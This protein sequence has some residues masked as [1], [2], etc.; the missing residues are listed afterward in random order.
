MVAKKVYLPVLLFIFVLTASCTIDNLPLEPKTPGEESSAIAGRAFYAELA[1]AG[2]AE[3]TSFTINTDEL[4]KG[5]QP[6]ISVSEEYIYKYY[7]VT[8]NG[9]W[10]KQT[11]PQATFGD[12]N[13]IKSSASASIDTTQL[14]VGSNH[15][16]AYACSKVENS[17]NCHDNKWQIHEFKVLPKAAELNATTKDIWENFPI[18]MINLQPEDLPQVKDFI[19]IAMYYTVFTPFEEAVHPLRVK[20]AVGMVDAA[21]AHDLKTIIHLGDI[22][23]PYTVDPTKSNQWLQDN[24]PEI[25]GDGIRKAVVENEKLIAYDFYDPSGTVKLATNIDEISAEYINYRLNQ[26][27]AFLQYLINY[28]AANTI[29]GWYGAEEIRYYYTLLHRPLLGEYG[30]NVGFKKTIDKVDPKKRPLMGSL[31]H[32]W[33]PEKTIPYTLLELGDDVKFFTTPSTEITLARDQE[34]KLKEL[35]RHVIHSNYVGLVLGEYGS[36]NRIESY[37]TIQKGLK[38][39][40]YLQKIYQENNALTGNKQNVP[41]HKVFHAPDLSQ[42][43]PKFMTAA[44]ARHDFWSGVLDANGILIYN[45]AFAD[46]YPEVWNQYKEGLTL[47]KKGGLRQYLV[48]GTKSIPPVTI[49][50]GMSSI[51][52]NDYTTNGPWNPVNYPHLVLPDY[53][54]VNARLFK[55]GNTGYLIVSHSYDQEAQFS[56]DLG[57]TIATIEIVVGSSTSMIKTAQGLADSFTGID[58]R[59]YKIAFTS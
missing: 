3:P 35:Q 57:Q 24:Y 4:T 1:Q 29:V 7:Y 53:P 36:T 40:E 34:Q 5:E 28:D 51:P 33:E 43:G 27:E 56:I 30:L 42:D 58:A 22:A 39:I 25:I 38:A 13:W 6:L 26:D 54:A 10:Q 47:I 49:S 48:S 45:Y 17:W 9:Q 19:D 55:I 59:V 21:K 46:E 8:V 20:R 52:G 18:L 2:Y 44:H 11:F 32:N 16:V 23:H 12:S 50:K 37:H 15:V 14:S 41:D 31:Q